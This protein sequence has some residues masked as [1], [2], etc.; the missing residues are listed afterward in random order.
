MSQKLYIVFPDEATALKVAEALT[1]NP[2]VTEL[3][4]DGWL[5]TDQGPVYYNIDVLFGTGKNYT[6]SGNMIDVTDADGNV[7]QVPEMV[8]QPGYFING[9]WNSDDI[10][11]PPLLE[12]FRIYP[13]SPSCVFG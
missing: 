6:A 1:G 5:N 4:K 7:T 8:Q 10:P 12:Q 3:P 13:T 11:V 9:L 2:D